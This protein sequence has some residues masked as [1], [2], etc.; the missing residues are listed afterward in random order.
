MTTTTTTTNVHVCVWWDIPRHGVCGQCPT[1]VWKWK[2]VGL[3]VAEQDRESVCVCAHVTA[4]ALPPLLTPHR[5]TQHQGTHRLLLS[6]G[7]ASS[8]SDNDDDNSSNGLSSSNGNS[9]I[10]DVRREMDLAF[11]PRTSTGL[12]CP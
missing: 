8:P 1:C 10:R 11:L 12:Y 4:L 2:C 6:P 7:H 3:G 9:G 5:T